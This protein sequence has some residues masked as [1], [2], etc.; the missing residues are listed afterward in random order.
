M[1]PEQHMQQPPQSIEQMQKTA[2]DVIETLCG[3]ISMPVEMILRPFYGTRYFPIPVVFFTLLTMTFLPL[4]G[5]VVTSA[6]NMIPF[7][8]THAP[9]GLFDVGSFA[10]LFFVMSFLQGFRLWRRM[11]HPETEQLSTWEGPAFPFFRLIPGGRSFFF[12]RIFLEPVFVF[13]TAFLLG[14]LFIL[15]SSLTTYLYLA[16]LSM[17]MKN[18]IVWYRSWEFMRS[19]MDI[20]FIAPLLAKAAKNEATDEE[21]G[22]IHVV[23]LPKDTPADIR[24]AAFDRIKRLF[25]AGGEG[26]S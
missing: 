20:G 14:H 11:L 18:Y 16:A 22:S 5:S 3:I 8:G 19:R 21:L 4:V 23:R 24:N 2:M 10:T 13:L 15:Q 25:S 17:G 1:L 9:V 26:N 6:A 12:T 7:R